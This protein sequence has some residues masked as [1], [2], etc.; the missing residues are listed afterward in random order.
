MKKILPAEYLSIRNSCYLSHKKDG[1]VSTEDKQNCKKMAAIWY[2]K[3]FGKTV[4]ESEGTIDSDLPDEIDVE[5]LAEQVAFFG[6]LEAYAEWNNN[7][8]G[9]VN[10]EC[11]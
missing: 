5:I 6:T 8:D 3:K 11:D 1:K 10:S 2:Y 9:D 4:Q 7:L